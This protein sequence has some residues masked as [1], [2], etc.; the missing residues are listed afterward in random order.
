M[1]LAIARSANDN[2]FD[3]M[4][5]V[6]LVQNLPS[7]SCCHYITSLSAEI[8]GVWQ[9]YSKA[10]FL[11]DHARR[12]AAPTNVG[13]SN[14]APVELPAARRRET[15]PESVKVVT[16]RRAS[17]LR[18]N[19]MRPPT[20]ERKMHPQSSGRPHRNGTRPPYLEMPACM[21]IRIH[22]K[23]QPFTSRVHIKAQ[24]F[25]SRIHIKA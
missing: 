16:A 17:D 21:S 18:G 20:R 23:A 3:S 15:T 24:P 13:D 22:S 2:G 4:L 7:W 6:S 9:H 10:S 14:N 5:S 1:K 12:A 25:T 11:T 8:G 19:E